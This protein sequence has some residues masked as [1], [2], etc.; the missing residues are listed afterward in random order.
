MLDKSSPKPLYLQLEE[1]LR[2]SIHNGEWEPNHA[3]PSEIELSRLYDVSR[4][5][6]RSVVTQLVNEGLLYRVQ[7]KGTFVAEPKITTQSLAYMGVREQLERMGYQIE[8]KL[9]DFSETK[10]DA[11]VSDILEV[12]AGDA[13][14]YIRR[15]RFADGKHISLH[16]SY[17]PQSLAPGLTDENLESEQLCV[18]LKRQFG[19]DPASVSETLES[20]LA[21][22]KE[23][24]LLKIDRRFPLLM[25]E[26]VNK[27]ASGKIFEYSKVLFRGDKIK[28]RF[29]YDNNS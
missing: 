13:L 8:T 28:L 16:T 23:A 26:D 21:N 2:T 7:G 22:D 29:E 27:T 11:R 3:I 14:Y 24:D 4:M 19:L 25:L 10:A 17:I 9:V 1:I 15:V 20:V 18:I 5:T 12:S 6:T